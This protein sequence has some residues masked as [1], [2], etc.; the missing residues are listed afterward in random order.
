MLGTREAVRN[1]DRRD[2]SAI[3]LMNPLH[4]H[5]HRKTRAAMITLRSSAMENLVLLCERFAEKFL[6]V[7]QNIRS[8]IPENLNHNI[9]LK[10]GCLHPVA[11]T[12]SGLGFPSNATLV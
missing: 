6:P 9:Y 4:S 11:C 2:Y 12:R 10:V 7:C 8:H 5:A 3:K 1:P